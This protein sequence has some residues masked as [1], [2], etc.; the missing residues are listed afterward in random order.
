LDSAIA[1][2]SD[3]EQQVGLTP[4]GESWFNPRTPR[5]SSS[6][7]TDGIS[8]VQVL[9]G[10]TAVNGQFFDRGTR[11]DYDAWALAASPEFDGLADKWN[12]ETLLPY[13][14]KVC[15]VALH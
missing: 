5:P 6:L 13:F 8:S 11:L 1:S 7:E 4:P 2:Y 9:G 12:W 15:G 10:G 14:R 3:P